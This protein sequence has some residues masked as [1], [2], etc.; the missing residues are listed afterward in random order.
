MQLA[1]RMAA[2]PEWDDH[3]LVFTQPNGRPIDPRG[4]NRAWMALLASAG[5]RVARL[6]DARHTA[7]TLLCQQGVPIRVVMEILGHSQV[8]LTMGYT[9]VVP[10][11]MREAAAGMGEALWGQLSP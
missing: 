3:G 10:D 6:H 7:A 5:V 8:S 2:G 11:M 1:E 9:H 4:D